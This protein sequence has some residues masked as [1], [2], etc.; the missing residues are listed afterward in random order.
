MEGKFDLTSMPVM[1]YRM[2]CKEII[3]DWTN[4]QKEILA[5]KLSEI[6]LY[7]SKFFLGNSK[8]SGNFQKCLIENS[9][10]SRFMRGCRNSLNR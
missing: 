4:K 5:L 10:A 1:F 8:K 6:T 7:D 2:D 3:K 9:Q